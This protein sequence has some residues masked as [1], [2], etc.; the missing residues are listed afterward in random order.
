[1]IGLHIR[2]IDHGSSAGTQG[3]SVRWNAD[4]ATDRISSMVN[5]FP[6]HLG[7]RIRVPAA[8]ACRAKPRRHVSPTPRSSALP[9]RKTSLVRNCTDI[10]R[11]DGDHEHCLSR[12]E[13]RLR[14][15][16]AHEPYRLP[17]RRSRHHPLRPGIPWIAIDQHAG[18]RAPL[19]R[20]GGE[21]WP[22]QES[23]GAGHPTTH[24]RVPAGWLPEGRMARG[25]GGPPMVRLVRR[26]QL[27][28]G[29]DDSVYQ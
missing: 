25:V 17:C 6:V 22:W 21:A 20:C 13:H 11:A 12:C 7:R 24:I 28:P 1:L 18:S 15:G 5:P 9:R 10:P 16:N 4:V 26:R 19:P 2:W 3:K 8:C 27:C 23:A 29:L 14:K